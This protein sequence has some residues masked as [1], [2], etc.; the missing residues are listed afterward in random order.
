MKVRLLSTNLGKGGAGIAALR[1]A[2]C[3]ELTE[4]DVF[5]QKQH[6]KKIARLLNKLVWIFFWDQKLY[7]LF[8]PPSIS[9]FSSEKVR[10]NQKES[11]VNFIH[12][13]Q[14]D[15]ISI[16]R[17]KRV[18]ANSIFYCHDTWL[19]LG[20]GHYNYPANLDDYTGL[21]KFAV[22]KIANYKIQ[23]ANE[24]KA[25]LFPSEWLL[26]ESRR[27]GVTNPRS[28]VIP[29]P[30]PDY[31]FEKREKGSARRALGLSL[32]SPIVVIA[33]SANYLDLRKG[34]DLVP[35][36][37]QGLL[38]TFP[39]LQVLCLG[40]EIPTSWPENIRG[41]GPLHS[42]EDMALY[43]S[44][45]DVLVSP[46]RMD[47]LPQTCVE[48]QLIGLPVIAFDIG[49]LKETLLSE[50][51]TGSVVPP[52]DVDLLVAKC[53]EYLQEIILLNDGKHYESEAF[54]SNKWS[55]R[56]IRNQ[57]FDLLEQLESK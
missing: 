39:N 42:M 15:F 30:V 27:R 35:E 2:Q 12:W 20:I 9:I 22:R 14:N 3:L 45:A 34:L 21:R 24:A 55:Y 47:N 52:Y 44:A 6:P 28:F 53:A 11:V 13:V 31:F 49:G 54:G 32:D 37:S 41:T 1:W 56:T 50:G 38:K 8:G 48:A 26:H 51:Q 29:N 7:S 36:I 19:F 57:F 33:A 10:A 17:L 5:T 23:I 4:T 40:F 18:S 16:F 25:L 43:Y 46:S